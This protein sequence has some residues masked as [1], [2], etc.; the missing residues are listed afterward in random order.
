MNILQE[1]LNIVLLYNDSYGARN[2][3]LRLEHKPNIYAYAQPYRDPDNPNREI[4][5]WQ[6][7]MARWVNK[8]QCFSVVDFKDF[9]PRKGFVCSEYFY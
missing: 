2:R 4:P 3:N 1:S 6:K 5:Q 8:K 9:S 7:D